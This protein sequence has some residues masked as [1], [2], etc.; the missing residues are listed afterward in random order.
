MK[1]VTMIKLYEILYILN[2]TI[3]YILFEAMNQL[4]FDSEYYVVFSLLY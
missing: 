4:G 1:L 3:D 2:S